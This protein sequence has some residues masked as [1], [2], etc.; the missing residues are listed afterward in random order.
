MPWAWVMDV[1]M[2]YSVRV[3]VGFWYRIGDGVEI[4]SA[5]FHKSVDGHR[6]NFI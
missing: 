1:G 4:G 5:M 3:F 6:V 2:S